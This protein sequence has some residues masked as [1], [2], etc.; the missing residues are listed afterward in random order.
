MSK[1]SSWPG[2]EGEDAAFQVSKRPRF[3]IL[4]LHFKAATPR[5]VFR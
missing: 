1:I 2:D 5:T 4:G 3:L